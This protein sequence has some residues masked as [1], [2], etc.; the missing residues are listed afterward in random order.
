MIDWEI[1]GQNLVKLAISLILALPIAWDRE[2]STRIMGLR[3]YPLVAIGCCGYV[4]VANAFLPESA[5]DAQARVLQGLVTGIGFV[6]GGAILKN[7]DHVEGTA[8]AA[9]IWAIGAVG[10]AVAHESYEI[11][12]VIAIVIFVLLRWL[13]PIKHRLNDN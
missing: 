6:G 5:A 11:A 13:T 1:L 9:S 12:A 7:A 4:L 3:T 8:T 2:R 10:V